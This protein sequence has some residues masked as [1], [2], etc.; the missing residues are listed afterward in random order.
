MAGALEVRILLRALDLDM[1]T[2]WREAFDKVANVD[3]QV[4]DILKAA[5]DA[6]VSP[7]NSFGYM[8]GGIDSAYRGFFGVEIESRLQEHIGTMHEGEL[9]VGQAI[10]LDTVTVRSPFWSPPQPCA[11]P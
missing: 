5:A 10:V 4:G 3:I 1:A 8:D 9:P 11:C 7:S 6:I 2:A